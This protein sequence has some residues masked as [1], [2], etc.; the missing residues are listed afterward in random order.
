MMESLFSERLSAT[1]LSKF[2]LKLD[3]MVASWSLILLNL[4]LIATLR[5]SNDLVKSF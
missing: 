2:P 5:L 4:S 3:L 1:K